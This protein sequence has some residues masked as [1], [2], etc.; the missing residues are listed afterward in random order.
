MCLYTDTGNRG[1]AR[2]RQNPTLAAALTFA[3]GALSY[4]QV[5]GVGFPARTSLEQTVV[6]LVDAAAS[7]T[8]VL[9]I[10][11]KAIQLRMKP[12]RLL[13]E[14]E[15][16]NR[17]RHRGFVLRV[18]EVT[19]EGVESHLEL[20]YRK[21]VEHAHG[22]PRSVRQKWERI[23]G[24]WIRSDSWYAEY[25]VRVELDGELAHPGRATDDDVLRDNDV[26][27]VCEEITLRYRWPHVHNTS[28]LVAGQV[29]SGLRAGGWTG[30]V[31]RCSPGCRAP[32][33]A[34]ALAS[35]AA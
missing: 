33:T 19:D 26:L 28:C 16:R 25:G 2:I 24:R 14:V 18:L 30:T 13:A 17:L 10:L 9:D 34:A 11:I 35:A 7:E 12:G 21:R 31:K 23:R 22:L 15:R 32:G 4:P 3:R 5:C 29:A 27:L 20:E 8:Q 1:N 6:D